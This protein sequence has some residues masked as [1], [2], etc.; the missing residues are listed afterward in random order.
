MKVL[1]FFMLVILFSGC[2]S[3][4]YNPNYIISDTLNTQSQEEINAG[5]EKVE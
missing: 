5:D 1:I 3:N 2:A 4:G